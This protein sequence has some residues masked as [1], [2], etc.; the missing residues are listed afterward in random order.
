MLAYDSR[1]RQTS[2]G[3]CYTPAEVSAMTGLPEPEVLRRLEDDPFLEQHQFHEREALTGAKGTELHVGR[4]GISLLKRALG[5]D[6]TIDVVDGPEP[7]GVGVRAAFGAQAPTGEPGVAAEVQ[8]LSKQMG[9]T[10][11][12]GAERSPAPAVAPG[13]ATPAPTEVNAEVQRLSK[14]MG[15]TPADIARYGA[16]E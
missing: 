15:V 10:P 5:Q 3:N 13:A 4:M 2:V 11:A 12:G 16:K 9:V 14:Q 8:R 1:G 7:V 6:G